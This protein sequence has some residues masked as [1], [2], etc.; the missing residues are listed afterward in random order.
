MGRFLITGTGI[1]AKLVGTVFGAIL[2]AVP[3]Y[4]LTVDNLADINEWE[5]LE[6]EVLAYRPC[7]GDEANWQRIYEEYKTCKMVDVV[8][9]IGQVVWD[10]ASMCIDVVDAPV[11][12]PHWWVSTVMDVVSIVTAVIHPK[13]SSGSRD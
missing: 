11:I 3:L 1:V 10:A 7:L 6:K 2:Q 5:K 9:D 8:I 13:T 12:T 4:L